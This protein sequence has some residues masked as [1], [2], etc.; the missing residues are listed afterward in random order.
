M[1]DAAPEDRILDLDAI[2]QTSEC[3][4]AALDGFCRDHEATRIGVLL[5]DPH[6]I[7]REALIRLLEVEPDLHVVG[8][9]EEAGSALALAERLRPD[10]AVVDPKTS[11]RGLEIVSLI[12]RTSPRS[13][14]VVFTDQDNATYVRAAID[15]GAKG[16]VLR[17]GSRDE[18]VRAIRQVHRG[19]HFLQP[20]VTGPLLHR[21]RGRALT[22]AG[23]PLTMRE[24]EIL[25]HLA[26]GGS[27]KEIAESLSISPQTVK[28]HL[29]Q[30]FKKLAVSDRTAAVALALRCRLVE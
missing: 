14:V 5:V 20:E 4:T 10:I 12:L 30:L 19:H 28:T 2:L 16:Y 23:A 1:E 26:N 25:Q 9:A 8:Q 7:I 11:R 27:N 3:S 29:K 22:E 15:A 24:L 6:E 17:R 13:R 21:L 18:L